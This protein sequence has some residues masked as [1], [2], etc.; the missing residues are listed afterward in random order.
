VDVAVDMVKLYLCWSEVEGLRRAEVAGAERG[1]ESVDVNWGR[2]WT[3]GEGDCTFYGR[4]EV[5]VA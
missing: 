2:Q 3:G 4:Y 1:G 5:F